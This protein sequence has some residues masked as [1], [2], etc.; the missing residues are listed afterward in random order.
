MCRILGNREA[1]VDSASRFVVMYRLGRI[2]VPAAAEI[3]T[4]AGTRCNDDSWA[5]VM[6]AVGRIDQY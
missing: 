6:A 5:R 1:M 2:G 3:K 4:N